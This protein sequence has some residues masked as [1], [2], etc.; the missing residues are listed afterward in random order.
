MQKFQLGDSGQVT[1]ALVMGSDV[2]GSKLD[3][4]TTFRLLDFYADAGGELIDTANFYASWVPGCKGGESETVIGEWIRQRGVGNKVKVSS[5]LGFDYPDS[6]GG[7][8]AHEIETECDKSL[9]RLGVDSLAIYYAH[10]DD[11]ATPQEET[12]V[13]FDKLVRSGKVQLLGASNLPVWRIAQAN[14]IAHQNGLTPYKV[15]QQ[16][17]TYL[18]PRHGADF[19]PQIFLSEDTKAFA[20]AHRIALMAFSVLLGGAY[21]RDDKPLP[22]QFAGPDSDDRLAVLKEVAAELGVTPNQVVIAWLRG[23]N[24]EVL[25]IIFGSRTEQL[26]E[27]VDALNLQLSREHMAELTQAG[28]P[29]VLQAWLQPT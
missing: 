26:Q 22:S 19:G 3:R 25:P 9:K 16:R 12:M 8:N 27:N 18:R 15:I 14:T 20:K 21:T 13:A 23:S 7:L 4:K 1:S 5:K 28:N 17:Y 24:P 10:K 29:V 2:L 6:L 11:E